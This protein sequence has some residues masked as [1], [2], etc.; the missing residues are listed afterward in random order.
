MECIQH[1]LF[2]SLGMLLELLQQSATVLDSSADME[3]LCVDLG[4]PFHPAD[5]HPARESHSHSVTAAGS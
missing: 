1:A 2:A 4:V 3:P 5:R